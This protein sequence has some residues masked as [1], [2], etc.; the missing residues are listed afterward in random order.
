MQVRLLSR[1]R[2]GASQAAPY[3]V[4]VLLKLRGPAR[5]WKMTT[6]N[7]SDPHER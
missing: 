5:Y 4:G 7:R 6:V 2:G 1:P 3:A